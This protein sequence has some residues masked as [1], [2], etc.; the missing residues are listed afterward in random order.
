MQEKFE[1]ELAQDETKRKIIENMTVTSIST[2]HTY[3]NTIYIYINLR[4]TVYTNSN[5]IA[6]DPSVKSSLQP[7]SV[8]LSVSVFIFHLFC[9]PT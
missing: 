2:I 3:I 1:L 7:V 9:I 8:S 4:R 6:S 5:P